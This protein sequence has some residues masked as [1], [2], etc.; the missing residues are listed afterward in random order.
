[1]AT[2]ADILHEVQKAR[3]KHLGRDGEGSN[4]RLSFQALT[5]SVAGLVRQVG[6]DGLLDPYAPDASLLHYVR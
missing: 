2:R 3:I 5:A 6:I 4:G 1:M